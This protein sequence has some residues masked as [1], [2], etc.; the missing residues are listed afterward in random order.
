MALSILKRQDNWNVEQKGAPLPPKSG[1][2]PYLI[3]YERG[4]GGCPAAGGKGERFCVPAV[5][6]CDLAEKTDSLSEKLPRE[7][8][9]PG[10]FHKKIAYY[11][12][13]DNVYF[14]NQ[15]MRLQGCIPCS[16]IFCPR[17]EPETDT[18]R[19]ATAK[20]MRV[21]TG[22]YWTWIKACFASLQCY[23]RAYK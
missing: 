2:I 21:A 5:L 23:L 9:A 6:S 18:K 15:I 11:N 19:N 16:S 10:G 22:C 1:S 20:Q 14:Q 4:K 12:R 3:F 13:L 7:Q 8:T 17:A